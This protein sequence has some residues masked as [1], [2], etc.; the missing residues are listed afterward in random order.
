MRNILIRIIVF[1]SLHA[2]LVHCQSNKYYQSSHLDVRSFSNPVIA[3]DY[4]DPTIVRVGSDFYMT[5]TSHNYYPGLLIWHSTDLKNWSPLT[6][7]LHK[8]VGTVWAPELVYFNNKFYLYFPT[9]L[10]GNYVMTADNAEGPWSDPVRVD[11][12]G[13]DPG[14]ISDNQGNRYLYLNRG[15]MAPISEDGLRAAG[16]V[17][18]VYE[19]W[20]YPDDWA[21]ECFCLE[22]P[23]LFYN[24]GYYYM[25]SAQGGTAGP[26]TSHMAVVARSESCTGPWENSPYNPLIRTVSPSENWVSTGHATLFDDIDGNWYMVYH[27]YDRLNRNLGRSTLIGAIK[28]TEDGWPVMIDHGHLL[29]VNYK[30]TDNSLL[31]PD[32]FSSGKLSWQWSFCGMDSQD[33]YLLENG[34]LVLES[35]GE[36]LRALI[37]IAPVPNYEFSF[38]VEATEGVE[39]G[40]VLLYSDKEYAG[41]GKINQSVFGLYRGKRGRIEL[42]VP[43]CNYF[44]IRVEESTI[45]LFYST[46][47]TEWLAYPL[48]YDVSGYHTNMLSGF[49]SLK[50]A[51]YWKGEGKITIDDF[52]IQYNSC[53]ADQ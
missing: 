53:T 45:S 41:I 33:N 49:L 6:R 34:T 48:G 44:K 7:A 35:S 25:V 36:S 12:H 40:V 29:D 27:G 13:I 15:R 43:Y 18:T 23:K 37:G 42:D 4:P 39:A 51:V 16:E 30:G 46:D 22:S 2:F 50:P 11:M 52:M 38:R 28:W 31:Q 8:D 24:N 19:G 9:S 17:I 21:V 26:S 20:Q 14:H 47:G 10:G 32:D 3:G 5:H 1:V